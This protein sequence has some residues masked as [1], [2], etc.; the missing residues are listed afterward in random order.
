MTLSYLSAPNKDQWPYYVSPSQTTELGVNKWADVRRSAGVGREALLLRKKAGLKID[1]TYILNPQHRCLQ[2]QHS[3]PLELHLPVLLA[4]HFPSPS[5]RARS[6]RR[7]ARCQGLVTSWSA[8]AALPRTDS[9]NYRNQQLGPIITS[10]SL[11]PRGPVVQLTR[12]LSGRLALH[13]LIWNDRVWHQ[14]LLTLPA[15]GPMCGNNLHCQ[16]APRLPLAE[17]ARM[18]PRQTQASPQ[19]KTLV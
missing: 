4:P 18:N 7:A 13:N 11:C 1:V 2:R 16:I 14:G 6:R 19:T 8:Q 17:Q 3:N 10:C 12:K 15:T 5:L 9:S